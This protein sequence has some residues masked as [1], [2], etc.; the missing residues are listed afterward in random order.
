MKLLGVYF[1]IIVGACILQTKSIND[2]ERLILKLRRQQL[3]AFQDFNLYEFG[4]QI[5]NKKTNQK[6]SYNDIIKLPSY[7]QNE[8]VKITQQCV[9]KNVFYTVE[10]LLGDNQIDYKLAVDLQTPW[11]WVKS[12]G[13][14]MYHRDG[15]PKAEKTS[16]Q[17]E[18]FKTCALNGFD[19]HFSCI[20]SNKCE[21]IHKC[22]EI[23]Y[24]S[25][26]LSMAGVFGDTQVRF[27]SLG[28]ADQGIISQRIVTSFALSGYDDFQ[29]DGVLG[30]GRGAKNIET[31]NYDQN[32]VSAEQDWENEMKNGVQDYS[33]DIETSN[34]Q[35]FQVEEKT[36]LMLNFVERF[37]S[38]IHKQMFSLYIADNYEEYI[39]ETFESH[40]ELGHQNT[41]KYLFQ[42]DHGSVT[43]VPIMHER[44]FLWQLKIKQISVYK[45]TDN[46]K[47][48]DIIYSSNRPEII[49][50]F[51]QSAILSISTTNLVLPQEQV[52]QFVQIIKGYYNIECNVQLR[53]YYQVLC[54]DLNQPMQFYD[55][56]VTIQ[57]E[58]GEVIINPQHL[59]QDCRKQ[60]HSSKYDCLLNIQESLDGHTILGEVVLKNYYW[61]FDLED[62]KIGFGAAKNK[63]NEKIF[64]VLKSEVKEKVTKVVVKAEQDLEFILRFWVIIIFTITS[65]ICFRNA[66][67]IVGFLRNLIGPGFGGRRVR[68]IPNN[69]LD[70]EK[71]YEA[72]EFRYDDG[73]QQQ[74]QQQF[75]QSFE[76]QEGMSYGQKIDEIKKQKEIQGKQN[77]SQKDPHSQFED[78][79]KQ[80]I[81]SQRSTFLNESKDPFANFDEDMKI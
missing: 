1:F 63:Y 71:N 36:N 54:E 58:Q 14:E 67:C 28:S 66:K 2:N 16:I 47:Y 3:P 5:C 65:F 8:V 25:E 43:W 44:Y 39:D 32:N 70:E 20:Q 59:I 37:E 48:N 30:L 72:Q 9:Q 22:A 26:G 35:M 24:K 10:T 15:I 55:I 69:D 74:Q 61:M 73:L 51:D 57:F 33:D 19:K 45:H 41:Q 13:C 79:D 34:F 50:G 27:P 52:Q 23:D 68:I 31:N 46:K 62:D 42:N 56:Y 75:Q 12:K 76:M 81:E 4:D 40:I 49:R 6:K 29:G 53:H 17:K 78:F 60:Q 38:K 64:E 80:T 18:K 21:K 11:T 77:G 7:C